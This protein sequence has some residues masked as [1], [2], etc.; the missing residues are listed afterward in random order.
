MTTPAQE[1][2]QREAIRQQRLALQRTHGDVLTMIDRYA[3]EFRAIIDTFRA[4]FGHCP[5]AS[6]L[7]WIA[8]E[9][10]GHDITQD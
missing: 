6:D 2:D 3:V 9:H 7:L 5:T 8:S 10:A 1:N 4:E